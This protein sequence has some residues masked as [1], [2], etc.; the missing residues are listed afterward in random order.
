[1]GQSDFPP[2]NTDGLT[3]QQQPGDHPAEENQMA[4]I[5]GGAF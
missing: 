5:A 4:L 2:F 1:M 3:Q